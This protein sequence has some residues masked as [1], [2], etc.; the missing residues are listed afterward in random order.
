MSEKRVNRIM[1]AHIYVT[2]YEKTC[3][4]HVMPTPE[5]CPDE[6][7]PPVLS[8]GCGIVPSTCGS[9]HPDCIRRVR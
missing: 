2:D 5:D 4:K 6:T 1:K 3:A 9:D 8:T 7:C